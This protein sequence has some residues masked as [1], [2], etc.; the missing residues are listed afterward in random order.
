MACPTRFNAGVSTLFVLV[1]IAVIGAAL[2]WWS[3]TRWSD[4][5]DPATRDERPEGFDVVVRGYR[6]DE[7]DAEIA[8]LR[9]RVRELEGR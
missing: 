3:R 1:A 7:V 8:S 2:W 5:L 4:A 6:M 9:A